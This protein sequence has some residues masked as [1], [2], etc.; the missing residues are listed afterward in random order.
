[1]KVLFLTYDVPYPLIS[2][3]KVRAYYLIKN[4]AKNHQITLF[5]YYRNEE[6]KKYLPELKKYC[7]KVFI[8]K[9]RPPWSWENLLRWLTTFLP[10]P[11]ATYYSREFKKA[12]IKELKSG[13]YDLVHFES[14][15]PALYLPL[16]KK[17]GIKTLMGNENVEYQVYERFAAQKFFLWR[18]LL[19]LEVF[20]MRIFEEKLWRQAD[21]NIALSKKDAAMVEK[22]TKRECPVIPNGVNVESFKAIKPSGDGKTIIFVGTLIYQPNNDAIKYFLKEIYLKIKKRMPKV[23]FILVSWHKPGWLDKYL[24]DGSIKFIQD[25]ETPVRKFLPQA[26]A[27]VAPMRIASGTR[28]KILEAMAA[29]LPVVTTS[30]GIEGIEAEKEVVIADKP[31]DFAFEVVKLLKD[32]EQ[33]EKLGFAGRKLV[34]RLYD[35]S[36]ISQKLDKIYHA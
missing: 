5:S 4:L 16:V 32:R 23:K 31:D 21:A 26:D 10:F 3:G 36:K 27:F 2:G 15:Y 29:G 20:R 8:F 6:Q 19:K 34:T 14:F 35:W 12:L 33:R 22:V 30:I 1:M 18:W 28:I 13:G 17:L 9:R 11:S 25:K 7:Q 24:K